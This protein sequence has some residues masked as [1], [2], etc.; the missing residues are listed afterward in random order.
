MSKRLAPDFF[1]GTARQWR[2]KKRTELRAVIK[3]Y[4]DFFRGSVFVPCDSL[5]VFN[6]LRRMREELRGNWKP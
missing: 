3:A 4:D 6:D 2:V 1:D 5:S